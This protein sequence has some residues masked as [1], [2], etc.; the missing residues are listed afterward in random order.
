MAGVRLQ[1]R[2]SAWRA[3]RARRARRRAARGGGARRARSRVA[4]R[5]TPPAGPTTATVAARP[6]TQ[7]TTARSVRIH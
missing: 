4:A 2:A 5:R 1:A 3:G 6:G 7:G